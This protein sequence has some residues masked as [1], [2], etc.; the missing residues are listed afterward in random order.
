[1]LALHAN[2]IYHLACILIGLLRRWQRGSRSSFTRHPMEEMEV[3]SG[4]YQILRKK[5]DEEISFHI[6]NC[7]QRNI[8]IDDKN[9]IYSSIMDW[10]FLF[11]EDFASSSYVFST[12]MVQ[13][14]FYIIYGIKS[15]FSP[16]SRLW[17]LTSIAMIR[18]DARCVMMCSAVVCR[19][20]EWELMSTKDR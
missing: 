7:E 8:N 1:M 16:L 9:E 15:L 5:Y 20:C 11:F 4:K 13:A 19:W 17:C 18:V 10:F 3:V 6:Y 14:R 2:P 12:F